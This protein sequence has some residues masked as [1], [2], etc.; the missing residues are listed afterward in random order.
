M[1]RRCSCQ[2]ASLPPLVWLDRVD[3]VDRVLPHALYLSRLAGFIFLGRVEDRKIDMIERPR[4]TRSDEDELVGQMVESTSK[5]LQ[6][7]P[8]GHV[9]HR[10]PVTLRSA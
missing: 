7:F 2:R 4:L 5:A 6:D 3:R 8:F 9:D 10:W 1:F